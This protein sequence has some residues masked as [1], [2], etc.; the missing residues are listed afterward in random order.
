M[1]KEFAPD[2]QQAGRRFS[3]RAVLRYFVWGGRVLLSKEFRRKRSGDCCGGFFCGCED[4]CKKNAP[5]EMPSHRAFAESAGHFFHNQICCCAS[6]EMPVRS[7]IPRAMPW[8]D[9]SLPLR[10]ACVGLV[11]LESRGNS[12]AETLRLCVSA[13]G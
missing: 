3:G 9:S 2:F 10:G 7:L 6:Y 13:R 1:A 12:S 5:R 8:A 11:K 4:M